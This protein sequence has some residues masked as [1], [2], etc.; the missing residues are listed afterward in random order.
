MHGSLRLPR[1]LP[2]LTSR[3]FSATARRCDKYG[4]IGLGR[5]VCASPSPAPL[6]P[7]LESSELMPIGRAGLPNGQEFA[8][9]AR[10]Y[11]LHPI[12]RHQQGRGREAGPG[13]EQLPGRRSNGQAGRKRCCRLSG[14]CTWD[15]IF[16][17]H[18]TL[19]FFWLGLL[20]KLSRMM[21]VE[22]TYDL[23]WGQLAGLTMII[24]S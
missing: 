23:S 16:S 13:A 12:V 17:L 11:R 14:C 3:H 8:C 22:N 5:M 1:Q 10:S 21:N 6:S 20:S 24:T 2:T 7:S 4:F 19:F 9:E 18:P 15:S